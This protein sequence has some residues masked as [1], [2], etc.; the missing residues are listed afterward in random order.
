MGCVGATIGGKAVHVIKQHQVAEM[1][2][3]RAGLTDI[4]MTLMKECIG[5]ALMKERSSA[6]ALHSHRIGV[7]RRAFLGAMKLRGIDA[8][9]HTVRINPMPIG[10]I[11]NESTSS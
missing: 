4:T 11:A 6:S 3:T 1:Q 8:M 5:S 2:N 7:G 9:R 10:V